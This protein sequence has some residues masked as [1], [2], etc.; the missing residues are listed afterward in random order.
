MASRQGQ[1]YEGSGMWREAAN[2]RSKARLDTRVFRARRAVPGR[3][4]QPAVSIAVFIGGTVRWRHA[5]REGGCSMLRGVQMFVSELAP[6]S[7][8]ARGRRRSGRHGPT[9]E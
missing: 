9:R 8:H 2:R 5:C 3:R 1:L 7:C 4:D 6:Y